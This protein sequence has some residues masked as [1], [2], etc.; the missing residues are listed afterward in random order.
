MALPL[1]L[2]RCRRPVGLL[3]L[4]LLVLLLLPASCAD[5]GPSCPAP[6]LDG[7][8][9]PLGTTPETLAVGS[10]A[11]FLD[12]YLWR[13]F[14]PISPPGGRLLI[15][16]IRLTEVD[17]LPIEVDVR[18]THLWV[19]Y[20]NQCWSTGFTSEERPYIPDYQREKVARCGPKWGPDV[21]VDLI[22]EV[23]TAGQD[24][25]YL[26]SVDVPIWRTE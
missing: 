25:H 22:T 9:P 19:I 4:V 24:R 5:D 11:F 14:M 13:D 2:L 17:S 8:P 3:P 15:A 26:K 21:T 6:D 18:M 1:R 20:G 10:Q 7:E 16:V 12:C 23:R